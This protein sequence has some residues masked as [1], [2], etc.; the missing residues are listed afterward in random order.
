[1][2][3]GG[4]NVRPDTLSGALENYTVPN[5]KK[6]AGLLESGLPTRKA[7]LATPSSDFVWR[8]EQSK[9]IEAAEQG[10][11]VSDVMDFLRAKSENVLP[12]NVVIFFPGG[13]GTCVEP[14]GARPGVIDRGSR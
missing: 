13:G 12:D 14:G 2:R 4:R 1:M 9:L 8:I 7:E 6:L 10:Y 3:R 5:L 11:P